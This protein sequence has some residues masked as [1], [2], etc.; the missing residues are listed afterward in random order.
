MF[1]EVLVLAAT[2]S[3]RGVAVWAAAIVVALAL[4]VLT[5]GRVRATWACPPS[6][7]RAVLAGLGLLLSGGALGAPAVAAPPRPA[8]VLT[9]TSSLP[10]PARPVGGA[11]PHRSGDVVVVRPGDTLWGLA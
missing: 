5:A 6:L 11:P 2:W 10:V 7:R 4:E 9:G 1:D 8:P 3:L